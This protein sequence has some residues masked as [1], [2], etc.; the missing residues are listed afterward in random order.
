MKNIS[1]TSEGNLLEWKHPVT[2]IFQPGHPL[3]K[4]PRPTRRLHNLPQASRAS[5]RSTTSVTSHSLRASTSSTLDTAS[6][7]PR[8]HP[9]QSRNPRRKPP[10]ASRA[11]PR[12][13]PS[14]QTAPGRHLCPPFPR[15]RRCR[16][17]TRSAP[18]NK[19]QHD[20]LQR[21]P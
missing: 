12:P 20:Q 1:L 5:P 21:Y 19:W 15:W 14:A 18:H 4:G 16:S 6:I 10:Q 13:C 11:L 3:S 8:Q 17:R 2:D 7:G 9:R